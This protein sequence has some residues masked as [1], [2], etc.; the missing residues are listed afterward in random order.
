MVNI[1]F[2]YDVI[3]SLDDL[4]FE[5]AWASA[6][7]LRHYNSDA[8][9]MLVTDQA[10]ADSLQSEQRRN[11]LSLF[12]RILV[13][14]IPK[15]YSN[16]EKSRW[17]KTNLRNLIK[18]DFLFID[19]DTIICDSLGGLNDIDCA[20]GAVL[21]YHC[22]AREICQYDIF[23][24]MTRKPLKDIFCLE[25]D[26][27]TDVYN[28]GLLLVRDTPEAYKLFDAWHANWELSRSKGECRDQLSL[29]ATNQQNPGLITEICGIYNCQ[30]RYSMQYFNNAKILHTFAS[31]GENSLSVLFGNMIYQRIRKEKMLSKETQNQLLNAKNLINSP[32]ILVDKEYIGL[33][34]TSAF[35]LLRQTF[36]AD[37]K[38]E[39][40]A[41]KLLNFIA[42][43]LASLLRRLNH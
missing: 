42:C 33:S 29:T 26:P 1:T 43:A 20:V 28:S 34:F 10:T 8:T 27:S 31:Q 23:N 18:G 30:L 2:V 12:N 7:T 21:D 32:S 13:A 17:V 16:K 25:Y 4:Y 5:Q 24:A 19:A 15:E 35:L 37:G 3:S 40:C 6:W 22:H 14:D 38:M 41:F 36:A 11:A 9:I 39:K